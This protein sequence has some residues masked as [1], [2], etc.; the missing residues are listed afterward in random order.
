MAIDKSTIDGTTDLIPYEEPVEVFS[1]EQLEL[2]Y[3]GMGWHLYSYT[4]KFRYTVHR[5]YVGF[6]TPMVYD[7]KF[8]IAVN[9]AFKSGVTNMINM[10]AE[11]FVEGALF[12]NHTSSILVEFLK[13][14]SLGYNR[15]ALINDIKTQ[16]TTPWISADS[17]YSFTPVWYSDWSTPP[18]TIQSQRIFVYDVDNPEHGSMLDPINSI[19][20]INR[21]MIAANK[22][23]RTH[24][25]INAGVIT[26]AWIIAGYKE[27]VAV[28]PKP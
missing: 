13:G 16:V 8:L 2:K 22:G 14:Q 28:H 26:G 15:V 9:P 20:F 3:L 6:F 17:D 25:Y 23:M 1:D 18:L 11:P 21:W 19:H 24:N 5:Q 7:V 10:I 12:V 27:K 4:Y